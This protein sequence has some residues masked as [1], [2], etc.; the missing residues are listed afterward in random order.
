MEAEEKMTWT[1]RKRSREMG[2]GGWT[3]EEAGDDIEKAKAEGE[4]E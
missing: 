2:T 4:E 3:V 1:M